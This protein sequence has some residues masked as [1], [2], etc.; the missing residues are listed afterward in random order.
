MKSQ[1]IKEYPYKTEFHAHTSPVSACSDLKA[2]DLINLYK[3]QGVD[4]IVLTNHFSPFNIKGREDVELYLRG[5]REAQKCA[6]ENDMTVVL[7]VEFRF[8]ENANDYLI[9]GIE[10][11][12]LFSLYEYMNKG[13]DYF[14]QHYKRENILVFQAH[15]F[16]D[17]MT[18]VDAKK[19]DGIEAFN[20][21]PGHNSRVALAVKYAKQNDLLICGGT[22]LH[23]LS[24]E[25]C[26]LIRTKKRLQTGADIVDILK[27][28]EFVLDIFNSIILP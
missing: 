12:E 24:H 13:L 21:H 27:K 17:N 1:L 14:C 4:T 15:P 6:K 8:V 18:M 19:L 3:A 23:H 10:E 16:R 28:Q 26:C 22:D 5:F 20:M 2:E 25:G 11:D 9:Y 7:G